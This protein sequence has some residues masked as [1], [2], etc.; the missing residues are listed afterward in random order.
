MIKG[1]Y[2]LRT[3]LVMMAVLPAGFYWVALPTLN[4]WRFAAALESRDY[5][6]AERLMMGD[7]KSQLAESKG[8]LSFSASAR[9]EELSLADVVHGRR[10]LTYYWEA[11]MGSM[12][13]A[14]KGRE[15]VA[16]RRGVEFLPEGGPLNTSVPE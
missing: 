4:A 16:T 11:H 15:C 14:F 9:T 12:V 8:W 1:R 7:G 2:S 6:A 13:M 10:R 5:D 3:L